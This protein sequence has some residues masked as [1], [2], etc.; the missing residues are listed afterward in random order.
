MAGYVATKSYPL[1]TSIVDGSSFI[2]SVI[3]FLSSA[4]SF[5]GFAVLLRPIDCESLVSRKPGI[6]QMYLIAFL[7]T[8]FRV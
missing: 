7:L 3:R 5:E 2:G 4:T 8:P 6:M 1:P